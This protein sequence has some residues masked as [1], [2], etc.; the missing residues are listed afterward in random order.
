MSDLVGARTPCAVVDL[1][2]AR[3]NA[4]RMAARA[5]RLGARLRPHVK[6]HKTLEGARLQTGPGGAITVS[7]LAEARFFAD[8]GFRDITYAVPIAPRKLAEAAALS[9]AAGALHLLLDGEEALREAAACAAQTGVRLSFFLKV[10]CGYHRAGVDPEDPRSLDLARGLQEA[11]GLDFAGI[12]THAGHSYDARRR[13][14]ILP[15]AKEERTVMVA[16]AERLRRQGIEVPTVSIGSTPTLAVAQELDGVDEVRP[17]NYLFFD[18][19]QARIGSC[20]ASDVAFFVLATVIGCYP[21]RGSLLID[22]GA[23]ALSKDP[24]AVHADPRVGFGILQ[25][26]DGAETLPSMH[27]A[28]LSQEHGKVLCEEGLCRRFPVGSRLRVLPNHSCLTAALFDRYLV[29]E[30]GEIR[31]TWRPVRGW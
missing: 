20:R 12:L 21:E 3:A 30:G 4:R 14:E 6:T 11:P 27:L 8:G 7:T 23:L 1:P 26:A 5:A 22:A 31:G 13:E 29:A 18:A 15:V 17:G 10:D 9:E 2:V 16:F 28:A 19:F 24:G 25:T